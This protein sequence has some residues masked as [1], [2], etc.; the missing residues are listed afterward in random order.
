MELRSQIYI[1]VISKHSL[2]N[3]L[4]YIGKRVDF[5]RCYRFKKEKFSTPIKLSC[6]GGLFA[7]DSYKIETDII[8][9]K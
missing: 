8:V 3:K 9:T 1:S 7:I 2:R 6:I 4:S 5:I